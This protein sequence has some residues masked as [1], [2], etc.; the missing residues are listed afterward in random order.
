V[1]IPTYDEYVASLSRLTEHVDPTTSTAESAAIKTAAE[2]LAALKSI[3][4]AA[5]VLGRG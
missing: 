1:P 4:A 3:D 5:L 2:S